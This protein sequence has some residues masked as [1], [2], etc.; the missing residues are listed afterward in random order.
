MP[1]KATASAGALG[2]APGAI[3]F[4]DSPCGSAPAE[5][6]LTLTN[7]G[8][9]SM[10]WDAHVLESELFALTSASSGSLGTDESVNLGIA[11]LA[12]DM[13]P[14][15]MTGHLVVTSGD[16]AVTVPVTRTKLGGVIE[17]V[18]PTPASLG[19]VK[20]GTSAAVDVQLRNR[21]STPV[22]ITPAL[23]AATEMSLASATP[24]SVLPGS[25]ATISVTY[26][27][28]TLPFSEHVETVAVST[29][30]PLCAAMPSP[31]VRGV[32]F[33]RAVAAWGETSVLLD[34]G[35]RFADLRYRP[36]TIPT[37]LL[38]SDAV[39][40]MHPMAGRSCYTQ[41]GVVGLTCWDHATLTLYPELDGVV[42]LDVGYGTGLLADGTLVSLPSRT[43]IPSL[44]G[45]ARLR[46]FD[47]V[48]CAI[49]QTGTAACWGG[50]WPTYSSFGVDSVVVTAPFEVPGL[51][52][53]VDMA[54]GPFESCTCFLR[55]GGPLSCWG[56]PDAYAPLLR[57]DV[58]LPSPIVKL[59]GQPD[60][61]RADSP[62]ML[63]A[64]KEM[65]RWSGPTSGVVK[66]ADDVRD[67]VAS[68]DSSQACAIL[69]DGRIVYPTLYPGAPIQPYA[70]F[71]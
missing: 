13:T 55:R 38:P 69:T 63:T 52:D 8:A 2:V 26:T 32:A 28:T 3:D 9:T 12:T 58:V 7:Y 11:P 39:P 36:T 66:Q 57:T 23:D 50:G 68:C 64:S 22:T 41:P 15:P 59:I 35:V 70:G 54:M 24:I 33:A 17:V 56:D 49:R 62:L 31:S 44:T 43:A 61:Q 45:I 42:D 1:L 65:Y 34:D 27:P 40:I 47:F 16:Q 4:G 30:D 29:T 19:R 18:T 37:H 10:R 48:E 67:V 51:D 5:R 60:R 53:A 14:G 20:V 6:T 46:G 71:D 21:G 25:T